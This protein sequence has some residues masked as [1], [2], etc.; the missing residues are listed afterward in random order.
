MTQVPSS[1]R[2]TT[3]ASQIFSNS[4]RGGAGGGGGG[5]DFLRKAMAHLL[6]AAAHLALFVPRLLLLELLAPRPLGRVLGLLGDQFA[7]RLCV[8]RDAARLAAQVAQVI[9]LG[10]THRALA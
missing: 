9:E 10:A 4:V 5:A 6:L 1:W 7:L 8:L 2:C 3:W